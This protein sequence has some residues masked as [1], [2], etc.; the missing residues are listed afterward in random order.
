MINE[1]LQF[2]FEFIEL[3]GEAKECRSVKV[4][5]GGDLFLRVNCSSLKLS[6]L[7]ALDIPNIAKLL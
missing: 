2:S 3:K 5:D 1:S 6:S 7:P 4:E